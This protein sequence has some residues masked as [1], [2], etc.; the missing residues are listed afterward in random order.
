MAKPV[1]ALGRA[2]ADDA[3]LVAVG[4]AQVGALR[5]GVVARPDA[6]RTF[7]PPAGGEG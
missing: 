3:D 1:P 2:M 7:V 5:V 4:I 6:R